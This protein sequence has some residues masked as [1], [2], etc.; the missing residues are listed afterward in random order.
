MDDFWAEQFQLR[1]GASQTT[2]RPDLREIT[3]ASYIDPVTDDLVR[4]NSSVI[5]SDVDNLD[6]RAEWFFENNDSF[7]VTLFKKDI[8]NPIE[9]FESAASDTNV[10][11]EII[12]AES[13]WVKGVEIEGLKDLS[14]L[15]GVFETLFVQG[16]LTL[17][18]SELVAGPNADSPTNPIRKLTG[19][20]DYVVNFLL[21]FDSPNA[22]HT[23]TLSYNVFGERLYVAG[24]AG[25]PDGFEQPFESVDLTYSWYPTDKLKIKAKMQNLLDSKIEIEREGIVT[26]ET[27]PGQTFV[28]S[29][30]WTL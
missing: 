30:Q 1:L 21:G 2:I 14:F 8:T 9:F 28:L 4:G 17:Q 15:G 29:A 27:K 22:K 16:N 24:R 25:A 23:A 11:R 12:N 20:S 5:P 19:A 18:D 13:A 6:I 7:T 26:Y 3:D 10:A